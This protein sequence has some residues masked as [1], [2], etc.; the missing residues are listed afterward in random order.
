[1]VSV[2]LFFVSLSY[3]GIVK[4]SLTATQINIYLSNKMSTNVVKIKV[5]T[6]KANL[7]ITGLTNPTT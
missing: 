6:I 4:S 3:G 7:S 1:M 5:Q 2:L